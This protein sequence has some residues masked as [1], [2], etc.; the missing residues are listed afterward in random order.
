MRKQSILIIIAIILT[1]CN[2]LAVNTQSSSAT[3][4]PNT[5]DSLTQAPLKS[6]EGT[7]KIYTNAK[8]GFS[9]QY[10]SNW[11]EQDLPDEVAGQRHHIALQGSEGGVELIWGTG[12]GGACPDGYQP[13]AVAKGS[14]PACHTQRDDGTEVWSLAGEPLGETSFG[15][16]VYTN[17]TTG[18]SRDIVLKVIST[19]SFP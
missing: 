7:W 8:V 6:I 14:L 11:Q 16:F 15:G 5:T 2:S 10:P 1:Y 12:L 4:S 19:L 18:E 9:I 17:D 3:P 13:I